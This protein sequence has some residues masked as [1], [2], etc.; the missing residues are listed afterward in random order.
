M[1]LVKSKLTEG[2]CELGEGKD[3]VRLTHGH[4]QAPALCLQEAAAE[5]AAGRREAGIPVPSL[6]F[7][8]TSFDQF[9]GLRMVWWPLTMNCNLFTAVYVFA[10]IF[11]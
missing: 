7:R 11:V 6:Q 2:H 5:W 8:F 1:S 10:K 4:F 9:L 3:G